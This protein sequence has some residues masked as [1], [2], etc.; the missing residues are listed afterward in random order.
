MRNVLK[1]YGVKDTGSF[2]KHFQRSILTL[3]IFYATTLA[4]ILFVSGAVSYSTFSSRIGHRFERFPPPDTDIFL[5]NLPSHL[6]TAEEVRTDFIESLILVNGILLL[7]A[8]VLSYWLALVTLYPIKKAYEKQRQ[9]LGNASHELRTP[10]SILQLDLENELADSSLKEN[11]KRRARSNLEEVGRM[12]RLV[13]DLLLLSRLDENK[14][15]TKTL[16]RINIHKVIDN[17]VT[18]LRTLSETNN[19]ELRVQSIENGELLIVSNEDLL[20]HVLTNIIKNAIV[21]NKPN[22]VVDISVT[23]KQKNIAI[24]ITD[25][26][27]GISKDQVKKIFDRFYRIEESRSRQTGGSGLGL[28]IV[29]SSLEHIGGKISM[30]SEIG[31]GTSVVITLPVV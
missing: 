10:L 21:Y 18:H 14:P 22:G 8:G 13:G 28:S 20:F 9:F 30:E 11:I 2:E 26:G 17:A 24:T 27:I 7:L 23:L 31:K 12:S 19:V 3:T 6:P 25:T 5:E 29:R 4:I 1:Q 16:N 15:I